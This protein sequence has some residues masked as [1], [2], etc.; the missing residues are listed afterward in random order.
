[1]STSPPGIIGEAIPWSVAWTGEMSFRLAP[2]TDFPGYTDLIQIEKP[3][4]GE[5]R[6]AA[7]HITRHR[8][9]MVGHLC[10][11]C[12]EPTPPGDRF[13]FPLESGGMV[14]LGDGTF[15]YGGNIPPVHGA[16]A[17]KARARC[18]HLRG[19]AGVLEPFP[20]E[21]GRV[22]QRTDVVPGIEA[23]ARTMPPGVPVIYT[24]YRLHEE[25]F[26]NRV[27]ALQAEHGLHRPRD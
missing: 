17:E 5:P 6:F 18:P 27:L 1:M 4:V 25:P 7:L 2:S 15:R 10:H 24:C 21:P 11:V 8:R 13:L 22:V 20:K 19:F 23:I 3:G 16:C 26:T 14:P 9:A 12:G